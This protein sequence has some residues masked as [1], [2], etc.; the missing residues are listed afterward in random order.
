MATGSLCSA[1]LQA[2]AWHQAPAPRKVKMTLDKLAAWLQ[3]VSVLQSGLFSPLDSIWIFL[4]PLERVQW[5]DFM[6]S[7]VICWLFLSCNSHIA[8]FEVKCFRNNKK[9]GFW[10]PSLPPDGSQ[11][12]SSSKEQHRTSWSAL[13]Y[14]Q[15]FWISNA[16][17]ATSSH[18]L[19]WV[20]EVFRE[21][22]RRLCLTRSAFS[23]DCWRLCALP[24]AS[25]SVFAASH[26]RKT[27]EPGRWGKRWVLT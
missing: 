25:F 10:F 1:S 8:L 15:S 4:K 22:H 23:R 5:M 11:S 12:F 21:K 16:R 18:F 26:W 14:E 27:P 17:P 3:E 20:P 9:N 7:R 24:F 13:V 6:V 19:T 2:A